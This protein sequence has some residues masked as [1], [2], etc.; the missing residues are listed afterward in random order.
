MHKY[1]AIVCLLAFFLFIQNLI[2]ETRA[3]KLNGITGFTCNYFISYFILFRRND[4]FFYSKIIGKMTIANTV[5]G[6][7][8]LIVRKIG[9]EMEKRIG[10]IK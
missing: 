9:A 7:T 5:Q 3:I 6:S 1:Q 2:T 8:Y 4:T 10:V